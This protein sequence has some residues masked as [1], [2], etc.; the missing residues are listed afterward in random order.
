MGAGVAAD[1]LAIGPPA[2]AVSR[3]PGIGA[4]PHVGSF[5][6]ARVMAGAANGV[7]PFRVVSSPPIH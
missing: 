3:R 2:I 5:I 4:S 7:G 6:I 1:A